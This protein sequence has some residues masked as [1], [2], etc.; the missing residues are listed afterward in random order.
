MRWVTAVSFL[1]CSLECSLH[2]FV[3]RQLCAV[4]LGLQKQSDVMKDVR[5]R[6]FVVRPLQFWNQAHEVLNTALIEDQFFTRVHVA[7][8]RFYGLP[9]KWRTSC[10][11]VFLCFTQNAEGWGRGWW[12]NFGD[13]TK[14][15]NSDI[16]NK[17]ERSD[18]WWWWRC[19]FNL[20]LWSWLNT[21]RC[22]WLIRG[23]SSS[24]SLFEWRVQCRLT[25]V[26]REGD[27]ER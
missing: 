5:K 20:S 13:R 12:K 14:W 11:L 1:V 16:S 3:G 15:S 2:V 25:F 7:I 9:Q 22:W 8:I 4:E 19:H 10:C 26:W 24:G 17:I 6:K 23:S 27:L 18:G 21:G